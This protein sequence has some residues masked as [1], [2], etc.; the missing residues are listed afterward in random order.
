MFFKIDS[1]SCIVS[2]AEFVWSVHVADPRSPS[3]QVD[4][5]KLS[6][7]VINKAD[8][9]S[10]WQRL[11]W[12]EHFASQGVEA[13]FFSAAME[14]LDIE[15]IA[16]EKKLREEALR[17][18]L[19]LDRER[20]Q[21]GGD[22]GLVDGSRAAPTFSVLTTQDDG[23]GDGDAHN[24][25][26]A[27]EEADEQGEDA[28]DSG[29]A[30]AV[31]AV[32]QSRTESTAEFKETAAADGGGAGDADAMGELSAEFAAAAAVSEVRPG[33]GEG[34]AHIFT[35]HELL[36]HCLHLFR[37]RVRDAPVRKDGRVTLGMVGYPNVGKSSTINAL[38]EAK[39]VSVA[40][41]PGHTKH[42]Q[43]GLPPSFNISVSSAYSHTSI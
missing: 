23:D 42:F 7:L 29:F 3:P 37:T 34:P 8:F 31:P 21:I 5:R 16:K 35:R 20:R 2:S 1:P 28:A 13:L 17:E 32:E 15:R 43:V 27:L 22:A 33:M 36:A 40:P 19:E 39:K 30:T 18:C 26:D 12:A 9:L 14:Q 38:C 25:F 24:P 41:T 4:S 6:V 11:A 10:E